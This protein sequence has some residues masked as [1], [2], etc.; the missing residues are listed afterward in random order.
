MKGARVTAAEEASVPLE[1]KRPFRIVEW[2]HHG[3]IDD[4]DREKVILHVLI[5][6]DAGR[7]WVWITFSELMDHCRTNIPAMGVY[8]KQLRQQLPVFW[9]SE[10]AM[11][12]KMR[13]DKLNLAA[14]IKEYLC[15]MGNHAT[16]GPIPTDM[17]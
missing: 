4:F 6:T 2:H 7:R 15:T 17:P 3:Y 11:L 10:V 13:K 12:K 9:P 16:V 14:H 5:Q 1:L 8:L